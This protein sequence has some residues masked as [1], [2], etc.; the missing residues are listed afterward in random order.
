MLVIP[1]GE[2]KSFKVGFSKQEIDIQLTKLRDVVMLS[3]ES[4]QIHNKTKTCVV[5]FQVLSGVF[6]IVIT[7]PGDDV[8]K[9]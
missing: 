9:L 6:N 7:N 3:P 1:H 5:T 2:I 8:F 4:I